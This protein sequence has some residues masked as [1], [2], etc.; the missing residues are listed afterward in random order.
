MQKEI[1]DE[2]A[3]GFSAGF[4]GSLMTGRS[5]QESY[6]F[7]CLSIELGGTDEYLT[8]KL[9]IK[10]ITG[11]GSILPPP[12]P[13]PTAHYRTIAN[14]IKNGNLVPFL[15]SGVDLY[16]QQKAVEVDLAEYLAEELNISLE[17]I[18]PYSSSASQETLIG[19]PCPACHVIDLDHLPDECPV[20]KAFNLESES[21]SC[22]LVDKLQELAVARVDLR[23]LAQY[24]SL[25]HGKNL[26][27]RNIQERFRSRSYTPNLLHSFF[28]QLP[29]EMTQKGYRRKPC[30]LIVSTT[31]DNLLEK[32]F[33]DEE[34]KYDLI[35]YDTQSGGRGL[36]RFM[37]QEHGKKPVLIENPNEIKIPVGER[38]IIL[39]LYGSLVHKNFVITE[40]DLM[41]YL[42]K[43]AM[44]ELLPPKILNI[45]EDANIIFMG[46]RLYAFS[47]IPS[48]TY[49]DVLGE[50]PKK[51]LVLSLLCP[52]KDDAE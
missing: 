13:L 16:G 17:E 34:E 19:F 15:G 3:I 37:Y 44:I 38:T 21:I 49:Q 27:Y 40:D 46:Y 30:P 23:A 10:P 25:I 14:A 42:V 51:F 52:P 22:P 36:G 50:L 41:K 47:T 39:K 1:T 7:G 29:W 28:A 8:P 43:D 6:D 31:C 12:D 11:E 35:F 18:G 20:K 5:Y 26:L 48:L 4:Y 24:Y 33:D 32:A 9:L 2:A 45:L